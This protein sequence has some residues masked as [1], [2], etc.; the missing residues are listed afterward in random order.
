MPPTTPVDPRGRNRLLAQLPTSEYE[1]VLPLLEARRLVY[2]DVLAR[3][4]EQISH[5]YFPTR[6]AISLITPM[7]DTGGVETATT[8]RDG[9]VGVSVLFGDTTSSQ[10]WLVQVP[11]EAQCMAVGDFHD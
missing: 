10:D 8:G 3:P 11:G 6:G 2:K 1:R 7:N 5:V 9:C 4:G